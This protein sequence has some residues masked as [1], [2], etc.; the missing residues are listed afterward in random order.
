MP[1]LTHSIAA[2]NQE[3]HRW[4]RIPDYIHER[5]L[6][7][8]RNP[9]CIRCGRPTTTPGHAHEDYIMYEAYL[10]AV[11]TDKAD[12]LCSAC[13][14]M[15]KKSCKPC[16]KCVIAYRESNGQTKIR[17]IPQFMEL[18][19]DCCDPG[20]VAIQKREQ[21]KF[22]AFVKEKRI[23]KNERDKVAR[24]PYLDKQNAERRKIYQER[25]KR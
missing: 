3:M 22:Q 24:R 6:F 14:F 13:N 11:K 10:N 2:H 19:R 12:P 8:I 18:C 17:Y 21:E 16:P 23:E 20:E 15:E 7:V 25:K 4:W 1:N 5:E 9:D